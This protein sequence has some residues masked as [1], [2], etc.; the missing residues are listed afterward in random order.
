GL[1]GGA[2]HT[3]AG[4]SQSPRNKVTEEGKDVVLRCDPISGHTAL[5]WYRQ[6]LGKGLEFLIYFQGNDA[7]D[8][9]GLPSGRFSAERTEGSVSTLKIQRTEQGDSAVY[10]CAS[11]RTSTDPQYFGP[12]TRLTV[13]E[14]LK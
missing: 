4:V 14:D 13:L 10:L 3:G 1:G 7:P 9:S 12:G 2:D 6:S 8:K 11:R 5:Y